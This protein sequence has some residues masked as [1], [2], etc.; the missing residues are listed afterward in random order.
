MKLAT[1]Q[2]GSRDGQLAVVSRDLS[3]AHFASHIA[4]TLRQVLDDWNFISPQLEDLTAT[5]NGGKAR[6]AFPFDP[7]RCMAPLPRAFQRLT[8]QADGLALAQVASDDFLPPCDGLRL[9]PDAPAASCQ[10]VLAAIT[11]DLAQGVDAGAALD[12]V[13]LLMLVADWLLPDGATASACAPVVLTPDELG[14]AWRDGRVH[15]RLQG[16]G[17]QGGIDDTASAM[18][19]ALGALLARAAATRRLRAGSIVGVPLAGAAPL[20]LQPGGSVRLD[21]LAHDGSSI[22]GGILQAAAPRPD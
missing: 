19:A 14:D 7:R 4:T 1:L 8:A 21:L 17:A 13:R 5:L 12:G 18:P 16:P 3:T 10:P 11:G 20:Q 2:D 9:P 22:F 6:H 15:A